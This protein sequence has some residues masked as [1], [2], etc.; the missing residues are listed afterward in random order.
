MNGDGVKYVNLI[1][2]IPVPDD[3]SMT[4]SW[5]QVIAAL[6]NADK[7]IPG[8]L[9]HYIDDYDLNQNK[10]LYEYHVGQ[11]YVECTAEYLPCRHNKNF[12][13]ATPDGSCY[14]CELK[15]EFRN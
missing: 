13:K 10:I 15:K 12:T 1:P 6:V 9:D 2:Y 11:G 14:I 5:G 7:E 3:D 4:P 8:Y